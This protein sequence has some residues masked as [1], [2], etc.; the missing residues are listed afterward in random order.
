MPL[1]R[2]EVQQ[3]LREAG[4]LPEEKSK[5]SSDKP[6]SERLDA[7]GLSLDETLEELAIVAKTS[8]NEAL[9]I[10]CLETV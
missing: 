6:L 9:R 3:I 2:P 1:I 7:A 10:R 4:L 5:K 8:G